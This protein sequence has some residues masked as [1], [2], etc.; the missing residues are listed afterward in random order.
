MS[1]VLSILNPKG[2]SGKSTLAT[3]L[4]RFLQGWGNVE[5]VDADPQGTAIDWKAQEPD[6]IGLPGVIHIH[7]VRTLTSH[8]EDARA[9]YQYIVIDGSAKVE[10]LTGRAIRLSDLVLIPVRPSPADL[11]G[12]ADLVTAVHRSATPAAF[13][14]SQQV[15]GTLLAGEVEEALEEYELPVL[16]AR[17]GHRQAYAQAMAAGLSVLDLEPDGKAAHEIRTIATEILEAMS[18]N[19]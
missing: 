15:T 10:R 7:D 13:V 17:T 2:G 8:I 1:T 3:N 14:I 12:V 16:T 18:A 19:E 9:L 5:I 4:A 11:W 6:G